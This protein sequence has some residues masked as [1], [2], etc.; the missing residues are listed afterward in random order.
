M[1][2]NFDTLAASYERGALTRRQLLLALAA[3][4][5][6]AA[7]GAQ[8]PGG[9]VMKARMLH[10]VNLQVSDVAQSEAFYRRLLGLPPSRIVQGPDNH[11]LDLPGG[12]IILQKSQTPG[13]IDHF[14]VGVESFDAN[15]LRAA[16]K[17]AGFERVQG[18]AADNFIVTD[19]DGVRVQ[20]SAVDWPA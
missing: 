12:L 17:A 5:A 6:P 10:H 9:A 15:R 3:M 14:C 20:V 19:P 1:T 18:T 2:D 13:R 11:G 8:A 7:A 16:A 4:A